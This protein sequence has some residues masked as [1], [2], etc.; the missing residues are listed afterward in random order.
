MFADVSCVL[1]IRWRT[2]N[3]KVNGRFSVDSTGHKNMQTTSR[4]SSSLVEAKGGVLG[5]QVSVQNFY[6]SCMYI[7]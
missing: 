5:G 1:F 6:H 3:M 2:E 7:I 4:I